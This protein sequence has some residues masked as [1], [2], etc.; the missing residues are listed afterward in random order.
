MRRIADLP[1]GNWE[2]RFFADVVSPF[3]GEAIAS[4]AFTI[5]GDVRGSAGVVVGQAGPAVQQ[6]GLVVDTVATSSAPFTSIV[7]C[8]QDQPN[9]P[10][11]VIIGAQI[12]ATQVG[13]VTVAP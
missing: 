8:K 13:D 11:P 2:L 12:I 1:A 6:A 9:S 10:S 7:S 3:G 4:C 5:N